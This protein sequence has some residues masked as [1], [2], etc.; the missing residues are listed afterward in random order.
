MS[1]P[2]PSEKEIIAFVEE[3]ER[4]NVYGHDYK[5]GRD[6]KPISV[7]IGAPGYETAN[8]FQSI[9]RY[10]GQAANDAWTRL[11]LYGTGETICGSRIL[12]PW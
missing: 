12:R 5:T 3:V 4:R 11:D 10:E 9:R 7:A 1:E 8:H 2:D 6:G